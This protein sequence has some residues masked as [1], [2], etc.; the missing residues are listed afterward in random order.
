MDPLCDDLRLARSAYDAL[1]FFSVLLQPIPRSKGPPE[2][3]VLAANANA[4]TAAECPRDE[5]VGRVVGDLPRL[6]WLANLAA[7][8]GEVVRLGTPVEFDDLFIPQAEGVERSGFYDIEMIAV[9]GAVLVNCFDDSRRHAQVMALE[10]SEQRFRELGEHMSDIVVDLDADG[11]VQWASA[12]L[13][14]LLGWRPDGV[15][16]ARAE[17]LVVA[18]DRGRAL[19]LRER[20]V[21]GEDVV[22]EQLR[23]PSASGDP[24][25]FS[26]TVRPV[27]DAVGTVVS[28]VA[29]VSDVERE[30]VLQRALAALSLANSAIVRAE[31]EQELLDSRCDIAVSGAGYLFS[32]YARA[33]DDSEKHI[34]KVAWTDAHHDYLDDLALSWADNEVGRGPAGSC[35]RTGEPQIIHDLTS[36]GH[37]RRWRPSAV[38]HGFRSAIGLPVRVDGVVDGAFLVYAGEPRAFNDEAVAILTDMAGQLA[39]GLGRLRSAKALAAAHT[40]ALLLRSAIDQA[41]DTIMLSDTRPRITYVN[42]AASR[43]TGYELDELMGRNP[44]VL[45]SGLHDAAFYDRMWARLNSGRPWSGVLVNRRKSGE[46]YEEDT[47]ISPV[48]DAAGSVVAFVAVKRDMADGLGP[49]ASRGRSDREVVAGL[50]R[51]VR[52]ADNVHATAAALCQA[53][54]RLDDIDGAMIILQHQGGAIVP[55]A[56]AGITLPGQAVGLPITDP[57]AEAMVQ[58]TA[59]APWWMDLRDPTGPASMSPDLAE[60]MR[61]VGHT[62][63]GNAPIR[64]EGRLLG[65]LAVATSSPTAA[66]WMPG[67]LA[68]LEEIGS[69]AGVLLGAQAARHQHIEDLRGEILDVIDNQRFHTVFE[70]VVELVSGT[71]V[72]F[73]ALTRFDD[74][75]SPDQRF[76]DAVVAGLE[77]E[78][79]GACARLA[80]ESA[81]DLPEGAWLSVNFS[82]GAL[83]DGRAANAVRQAQRPVVIEITEHTA[84]E[85]Y[86]AVRKAIDECGAVRVAVDDAGAGFASLRHILELEPDIIKLDIALV[87]DIDT[88]P[89]RQALAAGL[90]HFAALTGTT[91]IAEGVETLGQAATIRH[92]GV[93]F[94]QGHLFTPVAAFPAR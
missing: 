25:W 58:M 29:A 28:A 80:I 6:A 1:P 20:I 70:P 64:W 71:T 78:L 19:A 41:G 18:A 76:G 38:G 48:R 65:V 82:P 43:S 91:L 81:K 34:T 74:G 94:A 49:V 89:A 44:G 5:L 40:E 45:K 50:M 90:R 24:R 10:R 68:L 87:R 56:M 93:E 61:G 22:G 84:I 77:S 57:G 54:R 35:L 69:F 3:R 52:P 75:A 36:A 85:N 67:R 92:L 33:V 27:R 42:P 4:C 17:D 14:R 8:V 63:L 31:D 21:A 30:V 11:V 39:L 37:F 79:E 73:E 46:L 59:A 15:V 88:D 47:A 32:W 26:V 62:A 7:Q 86:R 53:V 55:V 13:L 51:E 83:L 9:D 66:A 2:L 12:S 60:A 72:G 16:G 23:L